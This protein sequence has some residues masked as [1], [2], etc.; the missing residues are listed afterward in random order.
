MSSSYQ[1]NFNNA[2]LIPKQSGTKWLSSYY[3]SH[4]VLF[5]ENTK[6]LLGK[7]NLSPIFDHLLHT[8]FMDAS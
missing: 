8:C 5:Q 7:H 2:V 4:S 6:Y 1:N 3:K